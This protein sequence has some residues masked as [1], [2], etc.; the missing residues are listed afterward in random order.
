MLR[1]AVQA[2]GPRAVRSVRAGA[3]LPR[4][5]FTLLRQLSTRLGRF[6][7]RGFAGAAQ[8]A[9]C[10]RGAHRRA[11]QL[12][13]EAHDDFLRA[14]K[15]P[16]RL[17][18]GRACPTLTVHHIWLSRGGREVREATNLGRDVRSGTKS[19]QSASRA[20]RLEATKPRGPPVLLSSCESCRSSSSIRTEGARDTPLGA[21]EGRDLSFCEPQGSAQFTPGASA[22]PSITWHAGMQS[23]LDP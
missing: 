3:E 23:H 18:C 20:V 2:A 17:K 6:L 1:L 21:T 9:E 14:R 19:A 7:D 16:S 13:R 11:A 8:K 10:E 15:S 5:E 22:R 12:T 4:R